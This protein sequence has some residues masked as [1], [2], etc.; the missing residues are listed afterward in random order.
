M[1]ILQKS[2]AI[3]SIGCAI[4]AGVIIV[5]IALLGTADVLGYHVFQSGV[6]GALELSSKG[7]AAAFFLALPLAQYRAA[8]V[9]VDIVANLMLRSV[10]RACSVI[11]LFGACIVFGV[12]AWQ[13]VELV[14]K[15]YRF[16]ESAQGILPFAVWP[17]KV[18]VLIG[19][20]GSVV[21]AL[22]QLFQREHI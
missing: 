17:F 13:A 4:I 1:S 22:S 10:Q 20:I 16:S 2:I 7:L 8:H 15:S 18:T 12:I 11:A 9:S 5:A 19:A 14:A 21:I 6:P 3:F